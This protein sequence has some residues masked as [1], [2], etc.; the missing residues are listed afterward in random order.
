MLRGGVTRPYLIPIARTMTPEGR[1]KE[2]VKKRLKKMGV[3]YFFPM[4]GGYGKSGVP[5][6]ICCIHGR[7]VGIECK[8][9]SAMPT[10]LQEAQLLKLEQAGG[11][12][13]VVREANLLE[14][15]E[16]LESLSIIWKA[17]E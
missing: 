16:A 8:A 3:Y 6:I 11:L 2:A 14:V 4:T 9:G 5:D 7:F 15:M 13:Y 1:V 17:N 10:K 12:A